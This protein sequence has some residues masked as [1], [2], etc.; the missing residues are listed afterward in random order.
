M[1]LDKDSERRRLGKMRT[2][3][4][5]VLFVNIAAIFVGRTGA[6]CVLAVDAIIFASM[7]VAV[8]RDID[9]LGVRLPE[10]ERRS[11]KKKE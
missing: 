3:L 7:L 2:S 10:P 6:Y 8:S 9:A 1:I 5:I 11:H 4:F